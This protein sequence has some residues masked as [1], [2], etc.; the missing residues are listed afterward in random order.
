MAMMRDDD[1]AV[2]I[3]PR[4]R[5]LPLRYMT[6]QRVTPRADDDD[7]SYA[8]DSCELID[9]RRERY[10]RDDDDER[11]IYLRYAMSA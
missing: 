3:T 7:S 4:C 9:E 2:P 8:K 5:A 6:R 11:A 10:A 1:D